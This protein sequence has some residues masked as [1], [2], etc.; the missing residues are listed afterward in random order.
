MEDV[1]R[2]LDPPPPLREVGECRLE[3][4]H[5]LR[6]VDSEEC[7]LLQPT[8]P[9]LQVGL[10]VDE[11][12]RVRAEVLRLGRAH[13]KVVRAGHAERDR[14]NREPLGG[15]VLLRDCGGRRRRGGGRC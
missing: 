2:L 7:P 11:R 14:A 1:Y 5:L 8:P 4:I 10:R 6:A 3:H 12:G 9:A 13:D 15:L